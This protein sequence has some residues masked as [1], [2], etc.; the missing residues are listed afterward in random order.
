MLLVGIDFALLARPATSNT[1]D[2]VICFHPFHN[3][4]LV[5]LTDTA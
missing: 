2:D 5:A 1:D 4:R 3:A